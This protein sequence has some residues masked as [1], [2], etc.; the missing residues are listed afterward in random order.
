[1]ITVSEQMV[2]VRHLYSE[3][4]RTKVFTLL[5]CSPDPE[6]NLLDADMTAMA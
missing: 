3:I 6:V 2:T 1:M 4:E 5:E